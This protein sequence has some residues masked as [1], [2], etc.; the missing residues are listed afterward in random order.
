MVAYFKRFIISVQRYLFKNFLNF[1]VLSSLI[2]IFITIVTWL[3]IITTDLDG[4]YDIAKISDSKDP[5]LF[6]VFEYQA[7]RFD[8]YRQIQS[9]T[10]CSLILQTMKYFYFSKRI[11]Q[12]L[13]TFSNAK[14][15]FFFYIF[16][17]S[18]FLVAF[19]AMAYF[20]FGMP[21]VEFSTF[22]KSIPKCLTLLIGKVD[23]QDLVTADPFI[24]PI[25]YFSFCVIFFFLFLQK[26]CFFTIFFLDCHEFN[27]CQ[28]VPCDFGWTL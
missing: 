15:D 8:F 6:N 24:G 17:F 10:L 20:A 27:S 26:F 22:T 16:M 11:S 7:G 18:I 12:L 25:F 19:S 14:L 4:R 3:Q 21:L 9:F 1:V 28:N 13:D 2:L 5:S 23:L